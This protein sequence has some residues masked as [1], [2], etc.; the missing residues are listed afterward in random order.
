MSYNRLLFHIVIRPYNSERVLTPEH[1]NDLYRFIWGYVRGKKGVLYR[2]NG[3]P[4]HIHMF[5]E[6]PA[7]V[8]LSDFMRS[9]KIA[10]HNYLL[11]HH[12]LFPH[13]SKWSEG[14]FGVT[15]G[16]HEKDKIVNY[17]KNQKEPHKHCSL[18]DE[19]REMLLQAGIEYKEKYL[20]SNL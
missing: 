1:K 14:Y 19:I 4:D 18:S 2:I 16:E 15:Y 5:L 7:S 10:T 20:F 13:F 8:S 9:L 11:S 3:M 6:I 12:D 17:I